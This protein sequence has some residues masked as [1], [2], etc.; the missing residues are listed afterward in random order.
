M[1]MSFEIII[2]Q[3]GYETK[4]VGGEWIKIEE[5]FFTKADI[6]KLDWHEQQSKIKTANPQEL[7]KNVM[8]Y[9]PKLEKEVPFE[10]EIFRQSVEELDIASVIKAVNKI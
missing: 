10:R 6:D 8:G 4:I 9:S 5:S 3:T 2:K 7:K 1:I